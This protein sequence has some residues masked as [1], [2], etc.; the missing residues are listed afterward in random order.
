MNLR[1][2]HAR[3]FRRV[4]WPAICVLLTL[5]AGCSGPGGTAAPS[6]AATPAADLAR[7][8]SPTVVPGSTPML[9]AS[10]A[11]PT[12]GATA[13]A[14]TTGTPTRTQ[15]PIAATPASPQV[16]RLSTP[17]P[18][19]IFC[20]TKNA[21]AEQAFDDGVRLADQGKPAEAEQSYLK[22]ISLDP[23]YCDAMDNLGRLLRVQGRVDEAIT[24]Y[25]KSLEVLPTNRVAL[26][27]LGA[28]YR[29]RELP[30]EAI[31]TYRR[32]IETKP[33]YPEGY[34][35]L[36]STLVDMGRAQE[37]L[38]PLQKAAKFYAAEGSTYLLDAY[39]ALGLAYEKLDRCDD[40]RANFELA[41][42]AMQDD[43]DLNY[44]LAGAYLCGEG[45]DPEK[46]VRYMDTAINLR[47][48]NADYHSRRG[49][50]NY[51]LG[52]YK[53]ALTDF[54]RV[55]ELQ[56]DNAEAHDNC[57]ILYR[58]TGDLERAITSH[59][60]AIELDPG[61]ANAY[62]NRGNAYLS[63]EDYEHALADYDKVIR[64]KPD[65]AQAY[66]MR[67]MV[68][69]A[70]GQTAPA[71]ANVKK[72]EELA[73]DEALRNNARQ[74]LAL[75]LA[76][77]APRDISPIPRDKAAEMI[78]DAIHRETG[79]D[80]NGIE[81]KTADDG[82]LLVRCASKLDA[83]D[84]PFAQEIGALV[85]AAVPGFVRADPPWETMNLLVTETPKDPSAA[86]KNILLVVKRGPA[87]DN[88]TGKLSNEEFMKTWK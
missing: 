56:P 35:G 63:Q 14:A 43:P 2:K 10:S 29:Y 12:A 1:S 28:A 86:A 5:A 59:T 32:L 25:K 75:L 3:G 22:A 78:R 7:L 33:D 73:G 46:A 31:A 8:P 21:G 84:A 79:G 44:R 50:A 15:A 30:E 88:Y 19:E 24:W 85:A 52:D 42:T 40:A 53:A 66:C 4:V 72:C 69:E 76:T 64:L 61:F 55:V 68:Y 38:E 70:R 47:P 81:V 17:A 18:A 13:A 36:G 54:D 51:Y 49:L 41:Y 62:Q 58:L 57:G 34:Y 74:Q 80:L 48:D 6:P 60:R 37:A 11:I 23:R 26:M 77:P 39:H 9:P 83:S 20:P 65:R 67:G 71:I 16:A 45:G 87:L 27:N 82:S